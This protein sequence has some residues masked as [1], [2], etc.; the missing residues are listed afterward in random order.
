MYHTNYSFQSHAA[1]HTSRYILNKLIPLLSPDRNKC[2]LDLGCGNGYL[3][4]HLLQ[5][6]YNVYGV[7][8]SQSGINIANEKSTGRFYFYDIDS[9]S[10]PE[11]LAQIP[12]DTV[13][14]LEVIEH[15]YTPAHFVESCKMFL[16][17][18]VGQRHIYISTPYHGYL[19]NIVL[20]V[21]GAMDKHFTALWD[22]GHIKFW[23]H[24]TITQ[25]LQNHHCKVNKII[26]CGR[27]PY[28]W[29]SMLVVAE[30]I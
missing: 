21:A 8:T 19:K 5:L 26:G 16:Q 22:G 28:L 4:H 30:V 20:A 9:L 29:K 27:I 1:P 6:G 3:V 23:S 11:P 14:S 13:I 12:F 10:I 25:L 17:Q 7:D 18:S 15:I 2:I 24:S